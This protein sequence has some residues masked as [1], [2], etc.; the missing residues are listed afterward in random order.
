LVDSQIGDIRRK[1]LSGG[2]RKR[3]SI[4]IELV[5]DP[6]LIMLDEPTSGLDSF[7]ARSICKLLHDLARKKGKTVVSTIHQPSSEAFHYFDRLILMADGYTVFQGD[8]RE[9]M[10]Y[11]RTL[12]YDVPRLCNPADFFMTN[13]SINYPK[14]QRDIDLL[15]KLQNAYR[16]SIESRIKVDNTLI[17]LRLPRDYEAGD[18][19]YRA[20]TCVQLEQL[21]YRSWILSK[22]EP[23][24]SRAKILQ[25]LVV[26]LFLIPVF[27]QLNDYSGLNPRKTVPKYGPAQY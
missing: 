7:K 4:G 1:I 19:P 23:R 24:I 17:K 15:D 18:K 3:T 25:T 13:L 5:S 20:S 26:A 10:E 12:K 11:F 22:R 2:E 14:K 6:S 21:F 9:S 8:A 16:F 27:W